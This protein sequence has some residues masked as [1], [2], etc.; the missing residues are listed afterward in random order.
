MSELSSPNKA[1]ISNPQILSLEKQMRE[2]D[3]SYKKENALL[4]QKIEL[5]NIQLK[6]SHEREQSTKR[7]HDTMISA[8]K[9]EDK[10]ESQFGDPHIDK[11]VKQYDNKVK[12][13]TE[14]NEKLEKMLRDQISKEPSDLPNH[15]NEEDLKTLEDQI[16]RLQIENKQLRKLL[17]NQDWDWAKRVQEAEEYYKNKVAQLEFQFKQQQGKFSLHIGSW[18]HPN[19]PSERGERIFLKYVYLKNRSDSYGR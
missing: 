19:T 15:S 7:L 12:Y 1:N 11:L 4:Q 17:K 2:R 9:N 18:T 5:L 16:E 3:N 13:L 14:R 10:E 6:D 8:F